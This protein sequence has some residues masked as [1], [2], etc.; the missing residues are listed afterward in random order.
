MTGTSI[1]RTYSNFRGV[2]FANEPSIVNI[3]RSPD[4]LN[5]WKNY[6]DTQGSCIET[7]PGYIKLANFNDIIYGFYVFNG[8]AFIHSGSN[9]YL[10]TNFPD[11]PEEKELL[12]SDMNNIRSSF[13]VF[14][15]KLYI[16]DGKNFLVYDE[17]LKNVEEDNAYIPTTSIT[18]T[19]LGGGEM[20]EDVNI[21][22]PLRKN[23]FW[24]DGTSTEY[25]LDANGIDEVTE[26]IVNDKIV[27][28]YTVNK[29]L[30]KI[31]FATAP[32]KAIMSDN[33]IITFRKN[34]E[35]Y[36]TRISKCRKM[37]LFDRR[38]FFT[39]NP[40]YP[41]GL[42]H[43]EL[44]NPTYIS[45][46]AYYQDG[47]E[48]SAIK[49]LAVGNNTLWVFKE[50]S[51]QNDTIF[52]HTSTIDSTGKVYPSYQGNVSTGCY[53][54]AINYKDD[55]VFLS[56]DGLEGISSENINSKQLLNHRSS[57][58]DNR[59]I[60][61][62][63]YNLS[64]M[65]EWEGYLL[66]LVNYKI[67]LADMR[68]MFTGNLGYEYEWYLWDLESAKICYLKEYK[69]RLYIGA[70]DGSIFVFDGTN[71]NGKTII[72]YW[73]TPMDN[74]GY[75]NLNKTTNKRGGVAKIKAIPNG[76]VKISESTDKRQEEKYISK[77]S[78]NGFDFSNFDFSSLSFI[79]SN[80][81]N[82]IY[83]IKEKKFIE[84]SLKFY[85][86]EL[87]KP[88]GLYNAILEAFVGGYVKK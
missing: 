11:T 54:D 65:T 62:N 83:K 1:K 77:F 73:T 2:D 51:Q 61:E 85:S 84:I 20:Y 57:L 9:L 72:S 15:N 64:M 3:S 24:A 40:D 47:S 43:C 5:I 42:F 19:P 88:F 33:V 66:I 14:N 25:Y 48:D 71:D 74:F 63:N 79:T 69:G 13:V 50:T 78:I 22:Q 30:G 38:I 86:D 46:L 8:K 80:K 27:T 35:G 39:G 37:V 32:T 53:A 59:L 76:I 87:N 75:D 4:A 31:T 67:Y 81:N 17:K 49:S 41:N 21:L 44:N 68:Q 23:S 28:D 26:V 56:R 10:W 70:E 18:R 12:K 6:S 36:K 58:V 16:L 34:I 29:V 52:Y 45:D 55:I 7:R 82:V 60:N